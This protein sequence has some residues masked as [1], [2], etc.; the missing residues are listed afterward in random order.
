MAI[1][2]KVYTEFLARNLSCIPCKD[3]IPAIGSWKPYQTCSVDPKTAETWLGYTQV[4]LICGT[5]S[6]GLICIDFDPKNG[7]KYLDWCA[8]VGSQNSELLQKLVVETTPSGGYHVIFRSTTK[9]GNLKL[10][11]NADGKATIE[12]RGEGGYFVCTPS[13]GYKLHFSNFSNIHTLNDVDTETL[14]YAAK[15]FNEQVAETE[16]KTTDNQNTSYTGL[17]PFDDFNSRCNPIDVLTAHGWKVVFSSNGVVYLQRPGKTERGISATWNKIPN[18]FYV[19]STSTNF[20][21]EHIYK[22]SAVYAILEHN[23]DFSAAAK[24]LYA[25]GFGKVEKQEPAKIEG[26]KETIAA[27]IQPEDIYSKI[28]TVIKNGYLKGLSTGWPSL[29]KLYSVVKGQ[30]T[31]VT[32]MPSHGKSEFMDAL[33]I[34]LANSAGWK[35]AV[36][37]PENYPVEMHFHKL[38]EKITGIN[39]HSIPELTLERA[40]NKITEH[41]FFIDALEEDINIDAILG[42]TEKLIANKS[43]DGLIIDPWNEIELSRPK[44]ISDSDFIGVCLRKLRKFARRHHIHLWIVAHP[45]KMQKGPDGKYLIPELYDIAGSAHW[46]NKADN[47][48]CVHRDMENNTTRIMVQKIKFRYCGKPGDVTFRYNETCG[49]YEEMTIQTNHYSTEF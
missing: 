2:L 16:S 17:T 13:P 4:A 46:R 8:I 35:F 20:E 34:N 15:S 22:A 14:I 23:G 36:F 42:Q 44:D 24:A 32:G 21:T 9:L 26:K 11:K 38:I 12:T 7:D 10:A 27:I 29:D 3:K 18:R 47:G 19:F 30:F 39:L 25:K 6:G 45:T 28:R 49:R 37:S 48:I 40:V 1:Q 5:V 41:F 33:A 43:I 31:V